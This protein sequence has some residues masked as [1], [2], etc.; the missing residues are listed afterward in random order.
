MS[1]L[2]HL[3]EL[4]GALIHSIL[5]IVVAAVVSWP[6]SG[7]LQEYVIRHVTSDLGGII[8]MA[9]KPLGPLT[10]RLKVTLA[11]AC[12]IAA[13]LV[14][15]RLWMFVAPGLLR[16]EKRL[17]IPA[18]VVSIGLFYAGFLLSFLLLGPRVPSILLEFSTPSVQNMVGIDDVMSLILSLSF[19]CGLVGEVPLVITFL[20]WVGILSPMALVRQWR[21][22]V[23][24]ILIAAALVT[25][26][27]YGITM[28]L[29]ALPIAGLYVMS[30]FLAFLVTRKRRGPKPPGIHPSRN[31]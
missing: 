8:F 9:G 24:L 5:F 15:S 30:V 16:K 13:P 21:L 6:L 10:A 18:L 14:L 7:W 4:R 27:D 26:G 3:E 25:P 23:V 31:A 1:F 22:A 28:L 2:E 11:A 19:A 12:L 17:A 20:S 29:I